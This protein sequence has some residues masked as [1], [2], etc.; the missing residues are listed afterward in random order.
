M[1]N[2]KKSGRQNSAFDR[3][4]YARLDVRDRRTDC[5]F[6]V[7]FGAPEKSSETKIGQ[8]EH[9]V[10]V[11]VHVTMVQQMMAVEPEENSGAFDVALARQMHAPVQVFVSAVVSRAR[12][13]G[14]AEQTPFAG[15]NRRDHKW[16]LANSNK[17]RAIP[18]SHWDGLFVLLLMEVIG[19]VRAKNSMVNERMARKR[20]RELADGPMHQ[21][22]MQSPFKK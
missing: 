10:E 2:R 21:E 12:K 19:V 1:I 6:E 13:H 4:W 11:F 18:P 5:L 20:I 17:R 7:N 8:R 14:A 9:H 3:R 16:E 22:P 15:P